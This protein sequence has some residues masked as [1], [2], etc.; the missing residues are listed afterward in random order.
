MWNQRYSEPGFAYGTA[1]NDFLV[2][3]LDR[4][5]QGRILSLGEGEGRNAAFLASHGYDVIAV[6]FSEVGLE[7]AKRLAVERGV[8]ITTLTADLRD[9]TIE[10]ESWEGV[11]SIFC[12]LPKEV[13]APLYRAVVGGLKP[14]GVF[15]LEAYTPRQREYGTGGPSAEELL[16]SLH[17]LRQELSGLQ[18]TLAVE[19]EREVLEGIYHHGLAQVVQVVG[20]KTATPFV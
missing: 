6:D 14:R 10:P 2:S 7:K 3:V 11:I 15:V 12:H 5:P 13:R 16:V 9:L 18:F 8:R 19:K 20:V 17:D 1:P 4:I